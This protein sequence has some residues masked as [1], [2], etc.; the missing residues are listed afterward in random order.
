MPVWAAYSPVKNSPAEARSKFQGGSPCHSA[1]SGEMDI[2]QANSKILS[3]IGA[4]IEAPQ[5]VTFNGTTLKQHPSIV[6]SPSWAV[7]LSQMRSKLL[8]PAN[9]SISQRSS[10]VLEGV[11]I[12]IQGL[13]LD[14]ALVIRVAEGASLRI[15]DLTVQNAGWRFVALDEND[16]SIPEIN[17]VRGFQVIRDETKEFVFSAPGEHV[18]TKCSCISKR[19][20]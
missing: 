2:Y 16:E 20:N 12:T 11:N 17:R 19:T 14:G 5:D 13:H 8:S 4:E 1:T 15:E 18:L 6:W 10:L 7:T 9:I 3:M